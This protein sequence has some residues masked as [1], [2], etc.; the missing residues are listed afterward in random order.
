MKVTAQITID[1]STEAEKAAA[2]ARIPPD[3]VPVVDL[4][5]KRITFTVVQTNVAF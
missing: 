1:Y 4:A 5:L 3:I 2:L